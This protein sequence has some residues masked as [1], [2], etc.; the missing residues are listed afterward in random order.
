[1]LSESNLNRKMITIVRTKISPTWF[2]LFLSLFSVSFNCY[3]HIALF[4][5]PVFSVNSKLDSL[6]NWDE[7]DLIIAWSDVLFTLLAGPGAGHSEPLLG[8]PDS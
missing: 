8:A 3:H 2:V 4:V 1:M 7:C 6:I 5:T